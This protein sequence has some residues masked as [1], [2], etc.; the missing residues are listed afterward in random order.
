MTSATDSPSSSLPSGPHPIGRSS[1]RGDSRMGTSRSP[2]R[3][4][5]QPAGAR[6]GGSDRQPRRS[7][8]VERE[9]LLPPLRHAGSGE[10]TSRVALPGWYQ[11]HKNWHQ[12]SKKREVDD[13]DGPDNGGSNFLGVRGKASVHQHE[14][15]PRDPNNSSSA[16]N[17]LLSDPSGSS[18]SR[19]FDS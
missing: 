10:L 8:A 17:R 5:V 6:A 3:G 18:A 2:G 12:E 11:E 14:A 16:V 7:A 1:L 19:F 4:I 9:Q 13:P 15:F